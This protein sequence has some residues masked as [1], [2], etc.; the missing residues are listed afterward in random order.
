MRKKETIENLIN[1]V[2]DI[3]YYLQ[4]EH[5]SSPRLMDSLGQVLDT[6]YELESEAE[7]EEQTEKKNV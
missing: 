4:F 6:L 2:V 7:F 3:K 1:K 5:W